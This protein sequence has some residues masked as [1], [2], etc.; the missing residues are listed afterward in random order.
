M[1]PDLD[2]L[3]EIPDPYADALP[4]AHSEVAPPVLPPSPTRAA[5]RRLRL[6]ALG[7]ALLYE[8]GLLALSGLRPDL[9]TL[10]PRSLALATVAPL[11]SAL[12]ALV[13]AGRVGGVGGTGLRVG[14]VLLVPFGLFS[15]STLF[16][17]HGAVV[18]SGRAYWAA[19]A[20]CAMGA[21]MFAAGPFALAV[22]AFR[23]GFA[24]AAEWRTAALGV[25]CG[26]LAAA[27]MNLRCAVDGQLHLLLGHG[28]GLLVA[29]AVGLSLARFTRS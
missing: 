6:L 19:T 12:L 21:V 15:L 20:M 17:A 2:R 1:D 26:A 10:A 22:H 4:S 11:V 8:V 9:A 18:L 25:G 24:S 29:G 27:A 13:A 7:C 5:V 23:R 28:A 3:L 14:A 16:A